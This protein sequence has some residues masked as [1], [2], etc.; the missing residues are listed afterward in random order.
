MSERVDIAIIGGGIVG[1]SL[2]YCLARL[3]RVDSLLLEQNELTSGSTWHAAGNTT[4]FGH[5]A[6]ITQLYVNSVRVYRD[7]ESES[8]QAI[9]FHDAG[10][11][12]IANTKA[13]LDAYRILEANYAELGIPYE[14]IDTARLAE[15]HPLLQT[16]GIIGAAHTP[17]DGH[18]DASGATHAVAA[19]ARSR[20]ARIERQTRV[21]GIEPHAEGWKLSTAGNEVIARDVVFANSF[22]AR[23]LGQ[24]IGIDI[25]VYAVKHQALVTETIPAI[26]AL[27]FELPT[28]RD[29]HG[30]Y[31]MRQEGQGLLGAVYES[32]P[33]FWALDGI[34]PDFNQELFEPALDNIERDFSRVFERV[35]AFAEAGIRQIIHGPI[36]YTP[37]ALPLLGPV[38]G[39][40]GLWLAT[41]FCVGIGTGGG[42]AEFLAEWMTTGKPPADLPMVYPS[43]FAEVPGQ[44][45]CIDAIRGIYA[46]GYGVVEHGLS[47]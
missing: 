28:I 47:V 9:G 4:F 39:K 33:Q 32:D 18:L 15:L 24:T 2:L 38:A 34:P 17:S 43:R 26:A 6:S 22:W 30:H 16:D 8:G 11:V 40:K 37:D 31:N 27:D 36:C 46:R 14:V 21:T 3:G 7:A 12:R 42:A 19:A 5:Y 35:P 10:S 29:S 25:P 1:C 45:E 44:A 23:E 13:E 20:G 41:G